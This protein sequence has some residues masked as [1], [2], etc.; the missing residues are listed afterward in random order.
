MP[1]SL[2]SRDVSEELESVQSVLIVSC[3]VC[4]QVSLAME[5]RSPLIELFKTGLKTG[6]F[7]D[8]I[9]EIREPLEQRGVRTGVFTMYGPVPTMCLWTRGQRNRLRKRARDYEAV[10][11]L[12]CESSVCTAQKA[13]EGTDCRVVSG[14]RVVGI[15]NAA[16]KY[17]F[18]MTLELEDAAPISGSRD[19]REAREVAP[20]S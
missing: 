10:L 5:K 8:Y 19:G 4:P 3:P 15:T 17:R 14:M 12:G 6:A 11:V 1:L 9:R 16:L 2:V 20:E 7:E 13:L 18:P